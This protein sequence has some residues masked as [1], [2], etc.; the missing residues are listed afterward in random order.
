[1]SRGWSTDIRKLDR[2]A[3]PAPCEG[4]KHNTRC[5]F[6]LKACRAFQAYVN[7]GTLSMTL[8]REPSRQIFNQVFYEDDEQDQKTLA[9]L[10]KELRKQAR[11][12]A[13]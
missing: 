1:M 13:V 10:R 4:C 12:E 8:K 3:R 6:E 5:G 11:A 7:T 9:Q 2:M